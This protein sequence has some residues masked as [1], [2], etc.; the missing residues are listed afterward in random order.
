MFKSLGSK[1]LLLLIAVVA[2]GLS[3]TFLLRELM[4]K[5]FREYLEGEREDKA[6]WVTAALES[7]YVTYTG[8]R[9]E[10]I[11]DNIVWAMML[12]IEMK[13]YDAEGKLV[14]DTDKAIDTLSP[15]VK[16]R[17]LA[18]S[19]RR[20]GEDSGPF[21]PYD[22]FLAGD[23]I[24]RI[25]VKFLS[26]QKEEVFVSR[27]N[28]FLLISLL[29]LGGIAVFLS[30]IFSRKMTRPIKALISAAASIEEG[31]FSSRVGASGDD[32][33]ANL[34]EAFNRMAQKLGVQEALR[35]K[36]TSNIAH[37]LRTPLSAVRGEL[38]AM[39]DGLISAD[40]EALQSLYAEIGRLKSILEGIEDLSL[41]EASSLTIRKVDLK[42]HSFLRS[43]AERFGKAFMDKGVT[44]ELFCDDDAAAS[45][46]PDKLSQIIINLLSNALKATEKGGRVWIKAMR[47]KAEVRLEVGDTGC[48]IRESDLPFI[49]ERFYR[50]SK[51]GLGLGLT[52]VKEL[53]EAQG[54]KVEVQSTYGKGS[55]FTLTLPL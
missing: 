3:A 46:D 23:Q 48:G 10:S 31:D 39:M 21:M 9:E 50:V 26:P 45:S 55:V 27:S 54:G 49:F 24:G 20:A 51:G 25:E 35:R 30:I 7:S 5:D 43:I 22:L 33:L 4:V 44:L 6:Y 28:R 41:A 36:L 15:F 12:G 13:L 19:E 1:F 37:E 34:S 2:V 52:I 16:K 53:A 18:I 47:D 8:W 14:M 17:V 29:A 32:E 40:K 11:I 38:E 42:L